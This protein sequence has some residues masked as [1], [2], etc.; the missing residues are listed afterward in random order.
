MALNCLVGLDKPPMYLY[1]S[2]VLRVEVYFWELMVL[3]VTLVKC[4]E[5]NYK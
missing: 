5:M 1:Q 4:Y 2:S 3:V